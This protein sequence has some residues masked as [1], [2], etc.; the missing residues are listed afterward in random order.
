MEQV[1]QRR[2]VDDQLDRL[3]EGLPAVCLEGPRAVGKTSTA[4]RRA[5]T[6]YDLDDPETMALVS[7]DPGQLVRG[8]KPVFID[9]W[10]RY[11]PSWDLVRRA[12]DRGSGPG[13]FVLAGS[14]SPQ[15]APTHSGA[16][17]DRHSA[18]ETHEPSRTRSRI[19]LCKPR[20]VARWRA[21]QTSVVRPT[22]HLIAMPLRSKHQASRAYVRWTQRCGQICWTVTW[23]ELPITICC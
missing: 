16:G 15:T 18:N 7:A 19:T 2:V 12:V 8:D 3:L 17:R 5:R 21:P 13:S 4:L 6:V 9:E 14:T 1:Y 23:I 10:Q 11:P 20:R 22:P